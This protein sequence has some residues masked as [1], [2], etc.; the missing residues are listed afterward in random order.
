MKFL[1]L[2]SLVLGAKLLNQSPAKVFWMLEFWSV[3]DVLHVLVAF[4]KSWSHEVFLVSKL[5][6]IHLLT[7]MWQSSG[8]RFVFL[9][10]PCAKEEMAE[11]ILRYLDTPRKAL[12]NESLRITTSHL[13]YD[14][15]VPL[16]RR[17]KD[18]T[19]PSSSLPSNQ[20]EGCI[21]A[22]KSLAQL[23]SGGFGAL[24]TS[25]REAIYWHFYMYCIS[26]V[27]SFRSSRIPFIAKTPRVLTQMKFE[28]CEDLAEKYRFNML[29][30]EKC[31]MIGDCGNRSA[32][33]GFCSK[34][35]DHRETLRFDVF[36]V[37]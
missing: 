37:A 1:A 21:S 32:N 25:T 11:D 12:S 28:W 17:H 22:T 5:R 18:Q 8:F 15:N 24:V 31:L 33:S 16:F 23:S 13:D 19:E 20:V 30:K 10:S 2:Q 34:T 14:Y 26:R 7:R 36:R 4:H 29:Q 9:W 3:L 27:Q 35:R 6:F